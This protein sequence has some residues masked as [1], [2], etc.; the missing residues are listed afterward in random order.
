[1]TATEDGIASRFVASQWDI[2]YIPFGKHGKQATTPK[3]ITPGFAP[4][5]SRYAY[6]GKFGKHGKQAQTRQFIMGVHR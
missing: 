6:F 1:M 5:A 4:R 3:S 2:Y